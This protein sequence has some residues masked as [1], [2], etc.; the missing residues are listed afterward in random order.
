MISD[1]DEIESSIAAYL[2][3]AV[4]R[5]EAEILRAHLEGCPLCQDIV[6]RLQPAVRALPMAVETMTPPARLRERILSAAAA[7]REPTRTRPLRARVLRLPRARA[8]QWAPG[9]P[10]TIAAAAVVA[11][12]LGAG[13]GLGLGRATAPSSTPATAVAQYSMSGSGSMSGAQGRVFELKQQDLT[14]IEFSDLPQL[15]QGKVYELWL[16]SKDGRAAPS[17]VFAPDSQG[18]RVVLVASNLSGVKTL[19]VTQEVGP[20]GTQAP[21]QQPQLLGSVG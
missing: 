10:T 20:S 21:T 14:I 15:E 17:G 2:L 3:G 12:A 6:R 9:L 18:S 13:F 11:F 7:S 19:A 4:D 8:R 1:H 5:E 16:I